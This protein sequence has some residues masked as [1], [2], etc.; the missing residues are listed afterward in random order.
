VREAIEGSRWAEA[1]D[2]ITR[3]AAALDAA[4][5]RIDAATALLKAST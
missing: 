2:Y 3:T 1:A 4:S 5:A